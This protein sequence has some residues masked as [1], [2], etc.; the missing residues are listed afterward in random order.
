MVV[1]F[2]VNLELR[3]AGIVPLAWIRRGRLDAA[4]WFLLGGAVA[5]P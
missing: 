3:A 1:A 4:Q 2:L 5:G